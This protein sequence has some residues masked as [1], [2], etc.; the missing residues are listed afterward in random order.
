MIN[1]AACYPGGPGFKSY[2]V[3]ELL[4]LNKVEFWIQIW[5]VTWFVIYIFVDL[6]PNLAFLYN[7]GNSFWKSV[8]P[9]KFPKTD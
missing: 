9:E 1:T 7:K 2:Y 6:K 3:R 4:I 5:I 8:W